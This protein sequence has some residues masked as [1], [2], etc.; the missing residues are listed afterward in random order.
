MT[1]ESKAQDIPILLICFNRPDK[2]RKVV[3]QLGLVQPKRIFVHFDGPRNADDEA[4]I[5]A[6]FAIVKEIDWTKDKIVL[7]QTENLGCGR[8]VYSAVSWFF[9][10]VE[11]GLILED[12][13]IVHPKFFEIL[14][15]YF[16]LN[17]SFTLAG[18]SGFNRVPT[19]FL[20]EPSATFYRSIYAQSIAWGTRREAWK[21]FSLEPRIWQT[22]FE[23]EI[24]KRLGNRDFQRFWRILLTRQLQTRKLD[25]WDVQWQAYNWKMNRRFAIT[26][27]N[28]ASHIGFGQSATHAVS[29]DIPKWHPTM[30]TNIEVPQQF[31]MPSLEVDTSADN[32]SN[33]HFYPI[34][35][36]S[37]LHLYLSLCKKK[38]LKVFTS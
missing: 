22:G 2:L 1:L 36:F 25:T 10:H 34:T 5:E 11:F 13:V 24:L 7:V 14:N 30:R 15:I 18:I 21:G 35:K 4:C 29:P 33:T 19:R 16:S 27:E 9:E 12:D 20:R 37:R 23:S 28:F 32:W 8:A 3:S 31:V 26:T 6:G 38:F 17:I